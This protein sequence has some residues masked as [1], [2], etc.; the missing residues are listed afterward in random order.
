MKPGRFIALLALALMLGFLTAWMMVPLAQWTVAPM[1][2]S[3]EVLL[4]R[5]HAAWH[6]SQRGN[7]LLSWVNVESVGPLVSDAPPSGNVPTWA[8]P[9]PIEGGVYVRSAAIAVG[10]P[11]PIAAARWCATRGDQGFPPPAERE[12]SGLAPK[13]ALHRL[14]NGDIEATRFTLVPGL[15]IDSAVFALLWFGLIRVTAAVRTRGAFSSR[16]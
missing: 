3:Q 2:D 4:L 10:W 6:G 12:D 7:A 8:E 1:I 11:M 14:I 13:E 15:L 9:A 5:G 16:E